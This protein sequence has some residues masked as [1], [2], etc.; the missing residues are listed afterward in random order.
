MP[1]IFN[2]EVKE[3]SHDSQNMKTAFK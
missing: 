3:N 1:P 2:N